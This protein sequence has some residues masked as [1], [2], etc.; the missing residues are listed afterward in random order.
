MVQ[1]IW[2]QSGRMCGLWGKE[3]DVYIEQ[4]A[5]CTG[6]VEMLGFV[7]HPGPGCVRRSNLRTLGMHSK[8][9]RHDMILIDRKKV[10]FK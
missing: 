5:E 2:T 7:N 10:V 8:R 9:V 4:R 1:M 6:V 3:G